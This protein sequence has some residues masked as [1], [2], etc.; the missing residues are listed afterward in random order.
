MARKVLFDTQ[1]TFNPATRT[2]VLPRAVPKERLV[3]ITNLTTNQ[4]IYNFSDPN[5]KATAYTIA[6]Q[7]NN[8]VVSTVSYTTTVVLNYNTT[9]MSTTDKLSI[10]IDEY[11]ERM[12]P[13]ETMIDPAEKFRV[14]TPQ[15]MIDTDFELS[16]QPSKWETITTTNQRAFAYPAIGSTAGFVGGFVG[17]STISAMTLPT[18]S[19]TVTVTLSVGTAPS[20]GQPIIVQDTILPIASG[21]FV[22]ETGGGGS[23]FTYTAKSLNNSTTTAMFDPFRTVIYPATTYYMA[24]IGTQGAVYQ[25]PPS[26]GLAITV[27]TPAGMVHGLSLGNPIAFTN[28]GANFPNFNGYVQSITGPSTFVAYA[29]G[30]PGGISTSASQIYARPQGLSLHRAFDGGIVF[31]NN[32][33][34]NN[35]KITRQTRRYFR[36]QSGKGLQV[37]SGTILKPNLNAEIITSSG[38]TVTVV[39]KDAHNIQPGVPGSTVTIAGCNE[40]AYNGTFAVSAVIN[41]NTFQYIA[42]SVPTATT[43]SGNY[44]VSVSG[45][46]GAQCRFGPFDDQ[47][48]MFW[49]F[50]GQTLFAV[51]RNSIYQIGGRVQV[52]FGS[53]VVTQ[54]D[55]N[56]P[57]TFSKQLVPGDYIVLRGNSYRV[58]DITSDTTLTISPAYRGPSTNNVVVS[59]TNDVRI[60]QSQWNL[61]KCDGTGPSGYNL[62]LNK[63]QMFYIDYTWYGAGSIRYGFRTNDG[64]VTYVH[65]VANNNANIQA[66]MRSGN[67]PARYEVH[68]KAPQTQTTGFIGAADSF[69]GIA[70]TAGFPP[71]G[72]ALIRDSRVWEYINY[73]GIGTTALT[74]VTRAQAGGNPSLTI[75]SGSVAGSATT[76]GIQIG[77]KVVGPFPDN[78]FVASIGVGSITH[79]NAAYTTLA[80]VAVTYIAMG[81]PAAQNF[82]YSLTA[83][84]NVELAFPTFGPSV[85]HWGSAVIM[86]GRYDDDKSLVFTYGQVNPTSIPQGAT[87]SLFSIRIAPSVDNGIPA[88]YG[89]REIVNRMQ[90]ILRTL[91]IAAL[92]P[93]NAATQYNL[94]ARIIINGIAYNAPVGSGNSVTAWTNAA[95]NAAGIVNSSFAQIADYSFAGGTSQTYGGEITGG[96]FIGSGANSVSLESV[97]DLGNAALGGGYEPYPHRNVYPD[98]P[99]VLTVLV[100]NVGNV[101]TATVLGRLSWTEAQA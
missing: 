31:S 39:V 63:M 6:N 11:E 98:G 52:S 85:S 93:P 78:T 9:S 17:L 48:G 87:R 7:T 83:P 4:V 100:T 25:S 70:S 74:G 18:G 61:D 90:L 97:R 42:S 84:V 2:I 50:D 71:A 49:E 94:L 46:Y 37:S 34:S 76:A 8:Q 55:A 27:T 43:A 66:Y 62:D 13:V 26:A 15:S 24:G 99:D 1:Y 79:S 60:P 22:V 51:R 77:Q 47:N 92:V 10:L 23:S 58:M 41:I 36:Y 20:N 32:S 88:A 95:N 91:D 56:N 30:F 72:T 44:Y 65:K 73:A 40:T 69:V 89:N 101:G 33:S 80:G 3:L 38:T 29:P 59:R 28:I 53:C 45:W 21:V 64:T 75:T 5:L 19:K 54:S 86:D 14:S 68:S 57:T 82:P 81:Y 35:E 67:L 16:P 96:F 12:R